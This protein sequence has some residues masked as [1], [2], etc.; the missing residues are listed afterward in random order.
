MIFFGGWLLCLLTSIVEGVELDLLHW[1]TSCK[2]ITNMAEPRFLVRFE[3]EV[4]QAK[5][6]S[7]FNTDIFD[8][9]D[10]TEDGMFVFLSCKQIESMGETRNLGTLVEIA[11]P[12]AQKLVGQSGVVPPD[13]YSDLSKIEDFLLETVRNYPDITQMVDMSEY[14][15]GKTY[16]GRTLPIIKISDNAHTSEDEPRVLINSA[17]HAREIVTPQIAMDIITWLTSG[18]DNDTSTIRSIVDSYEIFIAPVWNPDGY[19]Y[20]WT[21]NNMWRKNRKPNQGGSYGVDQNRNYDLAWDSSCGGSSTPSSDTYRGTHASSEEETM[22]MV[23]FTLKNNIA[24][25]IDF[26]SSGRDVLIGYRCEPLSPLIDGFQTSEGT[27][28]G[29]LIGYTP[30]VPSADGEHQEWTIAETTS[31]AFLVETATTFQPPFADAE[32]EAKLVWPLVLAFLE[33]PI[34]LHGRVT[35]DLEAGP[36]KADITI[37]GVENIRR[38][39]NLAQNGLYHLFLP[40]GEHEITFSADPYL[41]QTISVTIHTDTTSVERDVRLFLPF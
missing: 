15:P 39:S 18:Y 11:Q 27:S 34:S 19:S 4:Y 9:M 40:I 25:L 33:R 24:K 12:F 35:G 28:L 26:H 10:V 22:T 41:P 1:N 13:G 32:E 31:Y 21:D 38:F 16:E 8:D 5:L 3:E 6:K 36:I 7:Q 20:V 30:R 29:R 2:N 37:S 14:Y 23:D 17:H